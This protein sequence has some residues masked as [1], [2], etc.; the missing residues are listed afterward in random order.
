MVK[1][2]MASLIDARCG[3][4]SL[5][6]DEDVASRCGGYGGAIGGVLLGI[7]VVIA[8]MTVRNLPLWAKITIATAALILVPVLLWFVGGFVARR[9]NQTMKVE[10]RARMHSGMSRAEAFRSVQNLQNSRRSAN[11][12]LGAG[13][14]VAG[15][16]ASDALG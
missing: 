13:A 16:L 9:E 14:M 3:A 6:L 12:V 15:S 5:S 8:V 7:V 2:N 4:T 1:N 10:T 11:A